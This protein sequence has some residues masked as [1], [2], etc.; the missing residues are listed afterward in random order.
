M[1][2]SAGNGNH[3]VTV[4]E[5]E[6]RYLLKKPRHVLERTKDTNFEPFDVYY[7]RNLLANELVS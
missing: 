5:M 4:K 2:D 6:R 3:G 7:I 1:E